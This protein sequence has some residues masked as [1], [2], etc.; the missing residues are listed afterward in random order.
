MYIVQQKLGQLSISVGSASIRALSYK[1]KF[2]KVM[3]I[4]KFFIY[5]KLGQNISN[6]GL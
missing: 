5:F 1:P 3:I 6:L 2:V 4:L